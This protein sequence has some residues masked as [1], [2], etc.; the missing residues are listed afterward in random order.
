MHVRDDKNC[1]QAFFRLSLASLRARD[2]PENRIQGI[3]Q[4]GDNVGA[5]EMDQHA[6]HAGRLID[7]EYG[8]KH[9]EG[10]LADRSIYFV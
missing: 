1:R 2:R 7:E 9:V 8:F 10:M 5:D 3:I 6:G 4:L